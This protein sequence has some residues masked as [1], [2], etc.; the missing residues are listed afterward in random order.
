MPEIKEVKWRQGKKAE[1]GRASSTNV[2]ATVM[3]KGDGGFR[4]ACNAQ[5]TTDCAVKSL[6]ARM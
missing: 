3:K 5:F 2:E 4:L 1:E 6:L